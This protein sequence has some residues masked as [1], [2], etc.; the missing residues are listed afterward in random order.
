MYPD[1]YEEMSQKSKK[2]VQDILNKVGWLDAL[3]NTDAFCTA[4]P[5]PALLLGDLCAVQAL[6]ALECSPG[7]WA[8][9]L[10]VLWGSKWIGNSS[11]HW[12]DPTPF[13][14]G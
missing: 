3:M 4:D 11:R 9:R 12:E 1:T 5:D 2:G 7:S 10:H 14:P 8:V 6:R 13:V